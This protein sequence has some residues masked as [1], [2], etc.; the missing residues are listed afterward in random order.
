LFDQRDRSDRQTP[1]YWDNGMPVQ[2]PPLSISSRGSRASTQQSGRSI[3]SPKVVYQR[4][5]HP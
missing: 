4:T 1:S 3:F 2:S 5:W